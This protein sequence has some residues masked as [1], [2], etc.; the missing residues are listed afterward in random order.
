[1]YVY[2]LVLYN[3]LGIRMYFAMPPLPHKKCGRFVRISFQ[4]VDNGCVV[5][6]CHRIEPTI[7]D[8]H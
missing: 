2:S 6:K 5:G 1:M 7:M 8:G 4:N 3:I